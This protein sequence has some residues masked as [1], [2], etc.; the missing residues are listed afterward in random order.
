MLLSHPFSQLRDH[1]ARRVG[2]RFLPDAHAALHQAVT[3]EV[4]AA[5]T[6]FEQGT[7]IGRKVFALQPRAFAVGDLFP[8]HR[9]RVAQVFGVTGMQQLHGFFRGGVLLRQRLRAKAVGALARH[10]T[11]HQQTV[12]G[13][14]AEADWR[15]MIPLLIWIACYIGALYYFV[16]RV[17][18]R[19]VANLCSPTSRK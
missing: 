19:S 16:P 18:E 11:G 7:R 13:I 3:G 14:E 8:G 17:K 1:M 2:R 9:Q 15:L 10:I 12:A 5:N 6:G 4:H